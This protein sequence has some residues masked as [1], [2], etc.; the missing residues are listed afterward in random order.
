MNITE[1][2]TSK[3]KTLDEKLAQLSQ[4]NTQG[5]TQVCVM[6]GTTLG[7]SPV[8]EFEKFFKDQNYNIKFLEEVTTLPDVEDG[9]VVEGT[10]GRH[11][12]FFYIHN[13][14]I[15]RFAVPRL[16]MGIRWWED[17]LGNGH[18]NIYPQEVLDKYPKTW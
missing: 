12:L 6:E 7:D 14:D 1:I 11:D 4:L 5:Y 2:L 10:G 3:D 16:Q 8:D 17:V 13:D 15:V 9:R 18:G